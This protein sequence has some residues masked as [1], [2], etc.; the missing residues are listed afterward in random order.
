MIMSELPLESEDSVTNMP[1]ANYADLKTASPSFFNRYLAIIKKYLLP[2]ITITVLFG[3]VFYVKYEVT[4]M[5]QLSRIS[6]EREAELLTALNDLNSKVDQLSQDHHQI[7]VIKTEL[8]QVKQS[9]LTEESLSGLAKSAEL[10]NITLKLQQLTQQSSSQSIHHSSRN[11]RSQSAQPIYLP[12][13]VLSIDSMAGEVYAS[14]Q[15]QQDTLPLR[16]NE[17]LA[18]WKAIRLD[19]MEGIAVWENAQRRRLTTSMTESHHV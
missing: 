19:I 16:L 3:L 15:Y 9:M 7:L 5:K 4:I 8:D 10:K 18:G 11:V 12:F 13:Q 17:S 14:V 1:E 2:V 6:I